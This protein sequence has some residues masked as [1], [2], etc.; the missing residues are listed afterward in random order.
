MSDSSWKWDEYIELD[1]VK[2]SNVDFRVDSEVPKKLENFYFEPQ[3]V[4]FHNM[5]W[6]ALNKIK[7]CMNMFPLL[8][9]Y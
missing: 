3:Y 9:I 2:Y 7:K 8:F 5:N 1:V 4:N 6:K